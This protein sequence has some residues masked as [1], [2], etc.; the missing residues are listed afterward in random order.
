MKH[1]WLKIFIYLLAHAAVIILL[2]WIIAPYDSMGLTVPFLIIIP[3]I[4][5]T[6]ISVLTYSTVIYVK[7]SRVSSMGTGGATPINAHKVFS[8]IG[9]ILAVLLILIAA[10]FLFIYFIEYVLDIA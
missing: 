6:C 5:V 8:F 9:Y 1:I 3:G 10:G 4:I 2:S 7:R